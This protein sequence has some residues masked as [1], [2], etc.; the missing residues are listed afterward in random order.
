[1]FKWHRSRINDLPLLTTATLLAKQARPEGEDRDAFTLDHLAT[2]FA[3]ARQYR[4]S[5]P[6][7]F[8]VTAATA[9]T[10][11]RVEEICQINLRSDLRHDLSADRWYFDLNE[12][13]DADGV[14]RKSLKR[15]PSWRVVPIHSALVE[16][17]F[18]AYLREQLALG[19]TRPFEGGCKAWPDP[20]GALKWSHGISKW[21]GRELANLDKAGTLNRAGMTLSYFH[22][23]R[24]SFAN[25]LARSGV[26]EEFR[27]ALQGQQFGGINSERYAKMR[28]DH[29]HLGSIIETHLGDL[30]S[31]FRAAK[32][33]FA[34]DAAGAD[35][36]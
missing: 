31:V 23:M 17:G 10:G 26:P 27:S 3:N 14:I 16:A 30:V 36:G 29:S 11:C 6:W 24:H 15:K 7:K 33:P 21:G 2:L 13:P 20:K 22:S 4:A 12:E 28:R 18:I 25:I 35:A 32:A 1:M 8:W 9:M 5:E 34:L 19:H